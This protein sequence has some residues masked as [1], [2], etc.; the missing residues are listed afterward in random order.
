MP[1]T[2]ARESDLL[3]PLLSQYEADG[4]E[5]FLQP[6]PSVLPEFMRGFRPDAIARKSGRKIAIEVKRSGAGSTSQMRS[7]RR[8][9]SEHPDWELKVLYLSPRSHLPILDS[10]SFPDVDRSIEQVEE[11]KKSKHLAAALIMG[12]STLEAVARS[13]LPDQLGRPQPPANLIEA[14][15]TEGF[16]TPRE[17][18]ALRKIAATRNA[19]AHGQLDVRPTLKQLKEFI[20]VLRMLSQHLRDDQRR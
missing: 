11:L 16:L 17:A 6:S 19:A 14:L 13:L 20:A 10:V 9:F 3:E 12:W 7:L 8:I 1:R 18:D 5:V 2:A 15:A 4:F